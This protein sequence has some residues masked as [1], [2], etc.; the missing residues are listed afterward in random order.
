MMG[1]QDLKVSDVKTGKHPKQWAIFDRQRLIH[2]HLDEHG[3]INPIVVDSE[4]NLQFGGCRLQYAVLREWDE[5]DAIVCD[6]PD[7]IEKL[8]NKQSLF[9]YT[10][11]EE[12]Y[13]ERKQQGQ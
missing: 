8:Q 12:R 4:G 1:W 9:E 6:D 11:L 10:F 7:E 3:M 5:I 2:E 13:I